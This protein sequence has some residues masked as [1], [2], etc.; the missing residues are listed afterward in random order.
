MEVPPEVL[1]QLGNVQTT[2]DGLEAF[3]Q[4]FLDATPQEIDAKVRGS[5]AGVGRTQGA[6][7]AGSR[8]A[9]HRTPC[10]G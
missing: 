9:S 6:A 1:D 8:P 10:G 4:P 3:M 2:L 7:R 5:L